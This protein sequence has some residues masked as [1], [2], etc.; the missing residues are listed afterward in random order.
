MYIFTQVR[1]MTK[2]SFICMKYKE[3]CHWSFFMTIVN[4]ALSPEPA[5]VGCKAWCEALCELNVRGPTC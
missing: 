4:A 3:V 5:Q 2:D 1:N